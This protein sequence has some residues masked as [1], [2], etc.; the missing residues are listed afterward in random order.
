MRIK[1]VLPYAKIHGRTV[2]DEEREALFCNWT[3]SG[4]SI[5]VRGKTLKVRVIADSDFVPAPPGMPAPPSDWPC[6]AD[7]ED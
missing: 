2:Y 4:L 3:L 6:I 5:G 7:D 1:D